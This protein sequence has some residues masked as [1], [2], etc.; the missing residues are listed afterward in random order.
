MKNVRNS[1]KEVFSN[2]KYTLLAFIV[3]FGF[4]SFNALI[5]NYKI[6]FSSFSFKLLYGLFIGGLISMN[7]YSRVGLIIIS[8]LTGIL[9]AMIVYKLRLVSSVKTHSKRTGI[10]G[11]I[12]VFLGA[13]VPACGACGIGLLALLGYGSL[14][15]F[16]PFAGLELAWLSVIFLA[17]AIYYISKQIQQK[18]CEA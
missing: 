4:V 6:L 7:P 18:T 9:V 10:F 5:I 2:W 17:I 3:G 16:L 11:G 12:A 14:L 15:T 1:L 13:V 8:F